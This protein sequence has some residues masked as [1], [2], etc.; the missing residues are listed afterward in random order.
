MRNLK[1]SSSFQV[2]GKHLN[3]ST[4]IA[5]DPDLNQIFIA[6]GKQCLITID[7]SQTVSKFQL[8]ILY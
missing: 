8:Y 4:H 5:I 6:N 7:S 2:D 1:L 3:N